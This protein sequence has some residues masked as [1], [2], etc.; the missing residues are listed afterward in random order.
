MRPSLLFSIAL[1]LSL[2]FTVYGQVGSVIGRVTVPV[3]NQNQPLPVSV[4]LTPS[5]GID[6]ATFKYRDFGESE[7]KQMDMLLAGKTATAT[8]PGQYVNPPYIEYYVEVEYSG[9]KIE[10]YPLQDPQVNPAKATVKPIDPKNLEV[11]VLSPEQGETVASEDMVVAISLFYASDN[12]DRKATKI[13]LNNADVTKLCVF[14]DDVILFSPANFNQPLSLGL[15]FLRIQLYDKA[16]SLYHTV[17]SNFNLST[18]SAIEAAESRT[19]IGIDG[20]AEYR[21]EDIGTT[22]TTYTRGQLR[23]NGNLRSFNFGGNMMVTNE[24]KPDRQPQNRFAAFADLDVLKIQVG[25]AYPKFP[26]Y[27]VSG[28]R[29]RGISG[30]LFLKFFN[31]DVS[32]GEITRNIDGAPYRNF[33]GS[34]DSTLNFLIGNTSNIDSSSFNTR[35]EN[36]L[37]ISNGRYVV[38]NPG[39]FKRQFLAVRPSFGSGENFQLGFTYMKAKDEVGSITYGY[40]PQENFVGGTD[41]MIA[42]D[43][44]KFRIDAQAS[45]SLVNTNISKGNFTDHDY[46]LL[47]GKFDPD[48]TPSER[49]DREKQADDIK[50]I[51][52]IASKIITINEYLTPLN[53]VGT[54]LPALAYEGGL[55]LNYLNNYIRAQYYQRGATYFSFGNE[56]LQSDIRGTALSDR[57]R[58]FSNRALL[59]LSYEKRED[60]TA[61]SKAYTTTYDYLNTS[62]TLYPANDWPSF[63]LGYGINNRKNDAAR[64]LT[65]PSNPELNVADDATARISLQANYDFVAGA[66]HNLSVG[67]NIADKKDNTLNK[68]DQS[69]TMYFGSLTSVYTIP[70]QTTLGFTTGQTKSQ[71]L[72]DPNITTSAIDETL[73]KISSISANIQYRLLE[74]RMRLVTNVNLTSGD[75]KR[76]LIQA[77]IDYSITEHHGVQLQY[78]YIINGG[79]DPITLASYKNDNIMSAIYRFS[80]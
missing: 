27:I 15:Q 8:L 70:L 60:N 29:V 19:R 67:A 40:H 66:R 57:I 61:K 59:S 39:T 5:T 78:D 54:G 46:D 18:A 35:P 62:L 23:L 7:F 31:L 53:P 41:L 43:D 1:V 64:D 10:T 38:F 13:F 47:A 24:E 2:S 49:A 26:S 65:H 75:I 79:T 50:K 22:R 44:Q 68:R 33:A 74:D 9:G 71:Q 20:Q 52:N 30:N 58:L 72:H 3:V 48:L 6:R 76:T 32:Y 4:E 17:E 25:D 37:Q 56:F 36:S 12:V 21:N 69:N 16:G 77:S 11:R 55:T 51:A 73:L 63:T 28:K 80:F 45:L 34:A 42:F 14:S